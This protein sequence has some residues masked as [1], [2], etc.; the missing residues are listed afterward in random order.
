M[1]K[2]RGIALLLTGIMVAASP[3]TV[4]ADRED[5]KLNVPYVSLG[6]DLNA[7]EKGTVLRL[8]GV[9]EQELENYTVTTVTNQDEH[10]YLDSYLS[11]SVIGSRALSSVLVE[12]E[13]E[14]NGIRVTT[15]NIT[16]CTPGMYE[17]ALATAGIEDADIIVAGPFN[18]SG[19]AA[20]EGAIQ[21]YE[22]MT[23]VEIKQENV[24]T[25]TN[26]LVITGQVAE[27]V[28]DQEKAEQL[29]GAIKEQVVEGE[30]VTAKEIENVIDQAAQEMKIELSEE[31]RQAIASLMEKIKGLDLDIESL[32]EQA[33]NLYDKIESLDLNLNIDEEQVKGFFQKI[34]DFIR[35]LFE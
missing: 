35:G 28:G 33:K 16:Y 32:K 30:A 26:E 20:L 1:M 21:S 23:G 24:D 34:I 11:K 18:I 2:K 31:D 29:I 5:A 17:N 15:K 27:S 6:A 4:L 12:G 14:G 25:A 13:E 22:K 10:D 9:T 8:L 7:Q 19:T 3:V